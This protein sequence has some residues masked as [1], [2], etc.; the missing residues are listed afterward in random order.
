MKYVTIG[1]GGCAGLFVLL[2]I[3]SGVLSIIATTID[4]EGYAN[5]QAEKNRDGSATEPKGS[6]IGD[7]LNEEFFPYHAGTKLH[8]VR[9]SHL[10]DQQVKSQI[11]ISFDRDNVMRSQNIDSFIAGG[12]GGSIP[13]PA[14][15]DEHY[16]K[17]NG[18][19]ELGQM[20]DGSGQ[21]DW[22]P[23][24]K[25]GATAGEQWDQVIYGETTTFTVVRFEDRQLHLDETDT[26]V[27]CAVVRQSV[28]VGTSGS[29]DVETTFAKG[30]GIFRRVSTMNTGGKSKIDWR[31]TL[32]P[33]VEN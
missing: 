25:T 5:V 9:V 10:G 22:T 24:I 18:F 13:F 14:G 6:S 11:E 3:C 31:E 28:P 4:P 12:A 19:V 32:R 7:E 26:P 15:A 29:I 30:I 17:R 20:N 27:R 21:M 2:L 1:C 8:Y 23:L 33:P 16:R